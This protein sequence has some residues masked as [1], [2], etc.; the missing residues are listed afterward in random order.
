MTPTTEPQ[1]SSTEGDGSCRG[2]GGDS[3][4]IDNGDGG[5]R[6]R[7]R[8]RCRAT[9]DVAMDGSCDGEQWQWRVMVINNGEG[10]R[11]GEDGGESSEIFDY[12]VEPGT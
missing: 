10:G 6:R 8:R 11:A 3:S 7:R 2:G 9:A 5:G 4:N 1:S 12:S